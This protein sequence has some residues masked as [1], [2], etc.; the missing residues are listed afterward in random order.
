METHIILTLDSAPPP[1]PPK[2]KQA[3]KQIN[4]RR[5]K[6]NSYWALVIKMETKLDL[7]YCS[8]IGNWQTIEL[9]LVPYKFFQQLLK[10]LG[11]PQPNAV[12]NVNHWRP[13][14]LKASTRK[15]T[16]RLFD[17]TKF[18]AALEKQ[19]TVSLKGQVLWRGNLELSETTAA[20]DPKEAIAAAKRKAHGQGSASR[21]TCQSNLV[22]G[23]G[24]GRA[25][26]E[27]D[28]IWW[29]NL[30]NTVGLGKLAIRFYVNRVVL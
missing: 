22:V 25:T 13:P 23:G 16:Y 15:V 21:I 2:N 20:I 29:P 26:R 18:K 6:H 9:N 7:V 14:I 8:L 30:Y 10:D 5:I 27:L 1:P 24:D 4:S 19:N 28:V 12:R 3:N 17:L 11:D